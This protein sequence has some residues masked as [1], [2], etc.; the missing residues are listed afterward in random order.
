MDDLAA[1]IPSG[2]VAEFHS[3][4]ADIEDLVKATTT[5]TGADLAEAKAKLDERISAARGTVADMSDAIAAKGRV[6]AQAA[7][8]FVHEHPWQ[9]IGIGA[10]L[11]VLVGFALARRQ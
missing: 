7:D 6:A 11:G 2:A 4:V 10:A 9:A 1:T 8:G 5:L 3:F